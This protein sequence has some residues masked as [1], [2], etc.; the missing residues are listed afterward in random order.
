MRI[1]F[2]YEPQPAPEN[3]ITGS[4]PGNAGAASNVPGTGEDQAQL[5]GIHARVEALVD[6][7]SRLPEIRQERVQALRQL[8]DGGGYH[9]RPENVA[10]A[11]MTETMAGP[12]A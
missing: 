10:E 3:K 6:E 8:V 12:A 2:N 7:A 5:S 4:Q 1:N 9:P 11:M